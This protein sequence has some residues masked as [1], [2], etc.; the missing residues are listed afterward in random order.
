MAN[1]SYDS[2]FPDI[3]PHVGSCPDNLIE[4]SIRSAVI[5]F[6]EQSEAYR[7]ELDPISTVAGQFEYEFDVPTGTTL[8]SIE[9]ITCSGTKLEPLTSGLLEERLPD[10]RNETGDPAY[11]VKQSSE[12]FFLA[13][14]PEESKALAVRIRAILKPTYTGSATDLEVF[15]ANRDAIINGTLSRIL[16][17]PNKDWTDL[18]A[19]AIYGASFNEGIARAYKRATQSDEAI[20]RKVKYGGISTSTRHGKRGWRSGY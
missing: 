11:Y 17:M 14:V 10:W 16:R 2:I 8:H 13:P 4:S 19:A 7:V 20:S 18:N 12:V 9:W 1:I 15:N 6:C 3:I 5:E